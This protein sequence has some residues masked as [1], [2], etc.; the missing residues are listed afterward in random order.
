MEAEFKHIFWNLTKSEID[1]LNVLINI[2]ER[3]DDFDN[4]IGFNY[5]SPFYII[6]TN[7]H[8]LSSSLGMLSLNVDSIQKTLDLLNKNNATLY[9]EFEKDRFLEKS[10]FVQKFIVTSSKK[11]INKRLK[12]W[13]STSIIKVM[14]ENKEL[15]EQFYKYEKY[16]LRG[17]YSRILYDIFSKKD[18]MVETY[19]IDDFIAMVDFDLEELQINTWSRLSSNILKRA[20]NEINEKSNLYFEY[21]NVKDKLAST[22]RTQTM[23]VK[24]VA[25]TAPEAEFP[26]TYYDD[27]FLMDR[28][29][30]YYMERDVNTKYTAASRF[31]TIKDEDS[32]KF[33]V[34]KDLKK[35]KDEYEARVLLQEWINLVKYNNSDHHG[36][37][38]LTDFT[39]D[40]HFITVNNNYKLY[41]IEKK[42]ELTTSARDTRLKI[43]EFMEK[44]GDYDIVETEKF[45]KDCSI[46][47]TK[48]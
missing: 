18:R 30:T 7:M 16:G 29:I 41:D 40:N 31:G 26:E 21:E 46:S 33:S 23:K 42:Q 28:K 4:E 17:K 9:Y 5:T 35:N 24:I 37:V 11:D 3:N 43:N 45:L 44:H 34:R 12:M 15:F 47:Y 10:T 14:R 39:A 13:V 6:D 27:D 19:D 8:E 2:V 22:N 36:L 38:V 25:Q 32:Y 20:A 1:M 48:G